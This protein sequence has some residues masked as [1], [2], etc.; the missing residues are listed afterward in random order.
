[1]RYRPSLDLFAQ[2]I[3]APQSHSYGYTSSSR[4]DL[5]KNLLRLFHTYLVVMTL[6]DLGK[7]PMGKSCIYVKRLSDIDLKVLEKLCVSTVAYLN[8]KYGD[9]NEDA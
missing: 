5:N 8:E 3:V 9:V 4:L 7:F 1:M 2:L 6:E